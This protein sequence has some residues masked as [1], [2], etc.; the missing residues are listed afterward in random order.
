M[1]RNRVNRFALILEI[2][3]A[4]CIGQS[5]WGKPLYASLG[6][7]GTFLFYQG[8][9]GVSTH[10]GGAPVLNLR[11]KYWLGKRLPLA[12]FEPYLEYGFYNTTSGNEYQQLHS[13]RLGADIRIHFL[14][15]GANTG[16]NIARFVT[17]TIG[18]STYF[19]AAF[20]LGLW[21]PTSYKTGWMV[22]GS[23]GRAFGRFGSTMLAVDQASLFVLYQ[24][25]LFG[26]SD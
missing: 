6:A 18:S 17:G 4:T 5:A 20:R 14:V 7:S 11:L 22:A 13:T 10:V 15:L 8:A 19:D 16:F 21:L 26:G 23:W 2:C 9:A 3:F 1:L 12:R 25:R 24:F